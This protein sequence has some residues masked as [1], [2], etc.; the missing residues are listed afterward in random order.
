MQ[1]D[2]FI[3]DDVCEL[4]LASM[5]RLTGTATTYAKDSLSTCAWPSTHA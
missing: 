3:I 1:M 5:Y 4:V 2:I